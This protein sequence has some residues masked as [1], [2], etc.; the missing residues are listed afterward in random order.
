MQLTELTQFFS[1]LLITHLVLSTFLVC[2]LRLFIEN[3]RLNAATRHRLWL[4]TLALLLLMPFSSLMPKPHLGDTLDFVPLAAEQSVAELTQPQRGDQGVPL[5]PETPTLDRQNVM[6]PAER[7][8]EPATQPNWQPTFGAYLVQSLRGFGLLLNTDM[9]LAILL[10]LLMGVITKLGRLGY[11]STKIR[12]LVSAAETAEGPIVDLTRHLSAEM[13]FDKPPLLKVSDAIASPLSCGVFTP[14]ILLPKH[15][16]SMPAGSLN[17]RQ[18][19]LHELAHI[20]RGDLAIVYIQYLLSCFLFWHPAVRYV[21]GRI[22]LERELACDDWVIDH[23]SNQTKLAIK[24]Y[25][26]SLLSLARQ[27]KYQDLP[28]LGVACAKRTGNTSTRLRYLLD[29]QNNHSIRQQPLG[30]GSVTGIGLAFIIA[31]SAFWPQIPQLHP[32]DVAKQAMLSRA[33]VRSKESSAEEGAVEQEKVIANS[34]A[35]PRTSPPTTGF[36]S[37]DPE[38]ELGHLIPSSIV[39]TA[40][41]TTVEPDFDPNALTIDTNANE[42]FFKSNSPVSTPSSKEAD[43]QS[44]D[45]SYID[46]RIVNQKAHDPHH[47]L[48]QRTT[49]SVPKAHDTTDPTLSPMG[50]L[51]TDEAPARDTGPKVVSVETDSLRTTSKSPVDS[52]TPIIEPAIADQE[53]TRETIDHVAAAANDNLPTG[54]VS[55]VALSKNQIRQEIERI[56]GEIYSIYN[57]HVSEE[58]LRI[59]CGNYIPTGSH[60]PVHFCEPRFVTRSRDAFVHE[61]I[62]IQAPK[63]STNELVNLNRQNFELLTKEMNYLITTHQQ[64]RELNL[65]LRELKDYMGR[66]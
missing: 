4:C 7:S 29:D 6:Y 66:I 9:M 20:K 45:Q 54:S 48:P 58:N 61:T 49:L 36:E 25:A 35:S 2:F 21:N 65:T 15:L 10:A 31:T 43:Y 63:I 11:E 34:A 55:A 53:V 1:V 30:A 46:R 22:N 41:D 13:G 28:S 59:E 5:R 62:L 47:S 18:F 16:L 64:F 44:I 24:T 52:A 17:I 56:N 32:D 57:N 8:A 14:H 12:R 37:R 27:G 23:P 51:F 40:F 26:N 38:T 33:S 3:R 42:V 39:D 19:L 50:P 60:I